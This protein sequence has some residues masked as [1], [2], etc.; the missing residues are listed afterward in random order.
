MR[1]EAMNSKED[2]EG[3]MGAFERWTGKEEMI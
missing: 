2:K 1:K 3:S